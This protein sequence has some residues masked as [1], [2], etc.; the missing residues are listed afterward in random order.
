MLKVNACSCSK[1]RVNDLQIELSTNSTLMSQ[2]PYNSSSMSMPSGEFNLVYQK[3]GKV[4]RL[5]IVPC[6]LGGGKVT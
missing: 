2:N 1:S 4:S 5:V 3:R 6:Q